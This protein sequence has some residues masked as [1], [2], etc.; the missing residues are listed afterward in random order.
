MICVRLSWTFMVL[1]DTY[2]PIRL[3]VGVCADLI[4]CEPSG[5]DTYFVQHRQRGNGNCFVQGSRDTGVTDVYGVLE[6][7]QR[8]PC[9]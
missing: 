8:F 5:A 1:G 7:L 4:D 3:R 6:T 9:A 2:S